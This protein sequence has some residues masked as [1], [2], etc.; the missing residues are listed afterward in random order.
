[1]VLIHITCLTRCVAE[2]FALRSFDSARAADE[3]FQITHFQAL[4]RF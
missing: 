3:C 2:E 4:E 1:M